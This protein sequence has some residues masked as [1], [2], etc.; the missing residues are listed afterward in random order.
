MWQ[1]HRHVVPCCQYLGIQHVS[2][3]CIP[4]LVVCFLTFVTTLDAAAL[5]RTHQELPADQLQPSDVR[6][7]AHESKV[8][9]V[10]SP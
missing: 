7:D 2:I 4:L 8:S 10:N 3:G 9:Q 5:N 6:K 1:W